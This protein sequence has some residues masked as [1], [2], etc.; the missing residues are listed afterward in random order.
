[1]QKNNMNAMHFTDWGVS[2]PNSI[3]NP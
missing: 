1:M 3:L 2:P